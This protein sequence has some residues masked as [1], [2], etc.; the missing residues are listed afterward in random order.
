[1]FFVLFFIFSFQYD[2]YQ[3]FLKNIGEQSGIEGEDLD[4]LPVWK[5]NIYGNNISMRFIIPGCRTTHVVFEDRF[6]DDISYNF[7]ENSKNYLSNDKNDNI[8]GTSIVSP[9]LA[10]RLNEDILGVAPKAKFSITIPSFSDENMHDYLHKLYYN[11]QYDDIIV[12][13]MSNCNMPWRKYYYFRY[14]QEVQDY[15]SNIVKLGRKYHGSVAIV[16]TAYISDHPSI[17]INYPEIIQ[18]G[19]SSNRGGP[20]K[21]SQ[22]SYAT[23]VSAPSS[24]KFLSDE[25]YIDIASSFDNSQI[26]SQ[27]FLPFEAGILAGSVSLLLNANPSLS[28]RD[29][30]WIL[31]LSATKNDPT[32]PH[33]IK[34]AA[35]FR[36]NPFYGFGRVNLSAAAKLAKE[37][38][39]SKIP[40]PKIIKSEA[41]KE[42]IKIPFARNGKIEI[43]FNI[44]TNPNTFLEN[45]MLRFN[46]T[47]PDIS[48]L[49]IYLQSPQGT[50]IEL[51]RP[52]INFLDKI[53]KEQYFVDEPVQLLARCFFGENPNGNWTVTFIDSS[54]YDNYINF[55]ELVFEIIDSEFEIP[56]Q[57][58]FEQKVSTYPLN[59]QAVFFKF[60]LNQTEFKCGEQISGN[61]IKKIDQHY[62]IYL[63]DVE[64]NWSQEIRFSA[65]DTDFNFT[66]PCLFKNKKEFA[67]SLHNHEHTVISSKTI[68]VNNENINSSFLK[69]EPYG[70]IKNDE[71]LQLAIELNDVN[72]K[73]LPDEKYIFSMI[74]FENRLPLYKWD[75]GNINKNKFLNIS[76]SHLS[77]VLLVALPETVKD[78]DPCRTMVVPLI[79]D[80]SQ[81]FTV[82][83]NDY[84][85]VP[86]GVQTSSDSNNSHKNAFIKSVWGILIICGIIVAII[87]AIVILVIQCRKRHKISPRSALSDQLLL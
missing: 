71:I 67:L 36:F 31:L 30:Q 15:V 24:E 66:V 2:K 83:L 79:Y 33:W 47:N 52:D 40:T 4:I 19:A 34:N 45:V 28:Y 70:K 14:N 20:T 58:S 10:C 73:L 48:M 56:A 12:N 57:N 49:R 85:P 26:A 1:M 18:V 74:D 62:Y 32:N 63:T 3:F 72:E 43:N 78:A 5:E 69:P 16:P 46:T 7:K 51:K 54:F 9:A 81:K 80:E 39:N 44:N 76:T 13:T 64:T 35:G 53:E 87:I 17:L 50:K 60:T 21:H 29:I 11:A 86:E 77:K 25:P 6:M 61:V 8:K 84:C 27:R 22:H 38:S 75:S 68:L 59:N 41:K 65:T 55:A 37:W 23:L 42:K 82:P